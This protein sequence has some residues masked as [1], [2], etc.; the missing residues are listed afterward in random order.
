MIGIGDKAFELAVFI[1]SRQPLDKYMAL[2]TLQPVEEGSLADM[3]VLTGNHWRK[4]INI[5]AKLGFGLNSAGYSS[6]Q[7]YRD[8][9]LLTK[10]SKQ[11]LL[12]D[13]YPTTRERKCINIICGKTYAATL[14]KGS[15]LSHY[16]DDF[17]I[18]VENRIIVT[19]YFDYRQ[20]SNL[21]LDKLI[22]LVRNL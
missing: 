19:P 10:H 9:Y 15:V 4:I 22:G 5:Y 7:N 6:W 17:S 14:L 8:S 2:N 3:V 18:N 12:F 11:A 1:G 13:G 16:D 21:K 20:L